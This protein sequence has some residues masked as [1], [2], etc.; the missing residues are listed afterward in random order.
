MSTSEPDPPHSPTRPGRTPQLEPNVLAF[1]AVVLPPLSSLAVGR[2]SRLPSL[3]RFYV[4]QGNVFGALGLAGF[5]L[6]HLWGRAVGNGGDW[7]KL[8]FMFAVLGFSLCWCFVWMVQLVAAL[9]KKRWLIPVISPI[10]R[11]FLDDDEQPKD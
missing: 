8:G 10:T 11:R 2:M 7:A 6:I 3:V 1:F 9:L 4:V 5:V